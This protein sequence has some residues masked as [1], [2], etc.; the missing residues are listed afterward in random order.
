MKLSEMIRKW[1]SNCPL[2]WADR[3]IWADEVAQLEA[4]N[5][6]LRDGIT[7]I[8]MALH[9]QELKITGAKLRA[10]LTGEDDE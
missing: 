1:P 6:E 8:Y 4:E 10:L 5:E 3:D 2:P 7:A 9:G